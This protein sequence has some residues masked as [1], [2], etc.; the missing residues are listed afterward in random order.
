M[1][2]SVENWFVFSDL[3]ASTSTIPQTVETLNVLI[4]KVR[5]YEG[6]R[7]NGVLF[8]GDFFH[9][10][11]S[12]PVP[13]LNSLCST[14][15]HSHWTSTPT[16]M[17]PGNHDQITLSG[18]SHS[19]QFLETIMPK[20]RVI[21]E[22]T[23]LLNAAFVP[24]RR[25]PNIWKKDIPELINN[26]TSPIKAFFVHADVKG[27]KMNSNYTSKSELTLSQFPPVPIYSGHF[28]LPQTLKSK[29]KSKNNKITYIGSPYQQSFSEAGDVKRFLVLNKEFEVK[30]SLEVGRVGREY[31]IG[32]ENVGECVEGDVVR[33]DIVEGDTEAEE[34][35]KPHIQNLK[36]KGVDVI[37]R[38]IQRTKNNPTPLINEPPNASM[39]DSETTLSFLSS[40]NYTSE[41]PIHSKVLSTLNNVTSTSKPS[42]VNL[43]LSEID[44]KG[45]ASFKSK[46]EYPLGSRGLVLLKGGS[47][48]NGVGKT[49]LAWAGM[50]A[51]T[52]QLDER[53]VN[54]ASVVSI[55]NDRS[56]NAEVTL[57]GKVNERDFVVSRSKTKTKTRLSFFVDGKDETLQTAKDTQEVINEMCGSYSTLSRCVFLNQ[58]MSGDM[59][60]GSDSSLLEALSKL[61]DVDKF[62]E[63]RKICSEEARE[64]QK[65]RL[66]LEGGLSVRINDERIAMEVS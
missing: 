3:H 13:L 29:N 55:I 18:S 48:S 50:W 31:F 5:S 34:N 22:P 39:S 65:E 11:G 54:D 20:C 6:G 16:I 33:V 10:R 44:L 24:Y 53:A 38:R 58:F 36:D 17:I 26:Y 61:A 46:Q 9:S 43:E 60:S 37:I 12:I 23:I 28:H 47:S 57:R 45:F 8:L 14:L 63:A 52:G 59:L 56:K 51:L 62:R 27:A 30:E 35:V 4:N 1:Y 32:L 7:N 66:S 42:R 19:L 49:S 40:L 2:E 21:D 64:L 15:S 41:S 25:D